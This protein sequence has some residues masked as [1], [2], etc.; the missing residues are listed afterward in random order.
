MPTRSSGFDNALRQL[1]EDVLKMGSFAEQML[2]DAVRSLTEQEAS[3]ADEVIR[4]DDTIDDMDM[5][6]E[7]R[8]MRMLGLHHV[9]SRDLRIIGTAL[10]V[11]SDVERIGDYSVDIARTAK[12]LADTEYV[13]PLEDIPRMAALTSGMVHYALTAFVRRDMQLVKKV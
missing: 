4:R 8:G 10:K 13:A 12:E 5:D 6:I 7:A 3:L 2:S 9:G 11:I 1:Q